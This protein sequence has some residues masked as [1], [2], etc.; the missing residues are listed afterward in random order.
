MIFAETPIPDLLI[1][2]PEVHY[3]SRGYFSETYNFNNFFGAGLNIDFIQDNESKSSFGVL[4]GLHFQKPPHEQTKLVR[5]IEGKILDV[6][7][8]LRKKSKTFGSHFSIELSSENKKQ[9]LIPKGFAHGFIVLS[10]SATISYKVDDYYHPQ[11]DSGLLWSD[12]SLKINWI[13]NRKDIKVSVKDSNLKTFN[14]IK[15]PF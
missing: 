8:D 3:D 2:S 14:K 15:S 9:L 12:E 1:I 4:R 6:A 13:L 11:H 10:E 7:V 5:V